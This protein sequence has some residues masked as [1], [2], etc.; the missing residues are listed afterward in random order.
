MAGFTYANLV[1]DIRNYTEVD[2]NVLTT[3]IVNRIIEDA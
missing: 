1:T 2:A 3:A